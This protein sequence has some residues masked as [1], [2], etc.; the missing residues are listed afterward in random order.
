VK[1]RISAGD[2]AIEREIPTAPAVP[3]QAR[4]PFRL[5]RARVQELVA[6]N[7]RRRFRLIAGG[8]K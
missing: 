4:I 6:Q 8:S 2:A 1:L 5:R 3:I 7:R